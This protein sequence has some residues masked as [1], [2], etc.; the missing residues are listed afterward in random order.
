MG[1]AGFRKWMQRVAQL[2]RRQRE[3]LLAVL[4][5]AVDLDRVCATIEQ[6]RAGLACPDGG[7]QR[8]HRHG[9]DRGLQRY[10]C[11]ACKRTFNALSGTPLARLRHRERWLAYLDG[12]LDSKSVRAAADAIGVHRN[13]LPLASPLPSLGQ[14]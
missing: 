9:Y 7:G 8:L 14:T 13:E 11:C 5:P 12:M 1:G 2:T 10:R 6:T 3:Q 4:R